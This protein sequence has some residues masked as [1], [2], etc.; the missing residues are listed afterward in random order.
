M[1]YLW[2]DCPMSKLIKLTDE[3]GS[4]LEER[5]KA[6]NTSLAGEIKLL[7]DGKDDNNINQRLDNMAAFL[8]KEFGELRSLIEDTSVDRLASSTI[9]SRP[10]SRSSS[11]TY[12]DWPTVQELMFDW[13]NDSDWTCAAAKKGME[14][15]NLADEA[16][17][18]ISDSGYVVGD[19]YG[20]KQEYI[21]L[22]QHVLDFLNKK[23]I[24]L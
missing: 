15:S 11:T 6:D 12:L 4:V 3:I 5:A 10:Q 23:G 16:Q 20:E 24:V 9:S 18:Y 1:V 2:Y 19:F 17:W 13:A 22:T 7:L 14:D 21:K 8:K